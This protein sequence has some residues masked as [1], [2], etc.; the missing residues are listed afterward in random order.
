MGLSDGLFHNAWSFDLK[1]ACQSGRLLEKGDP[2][3]A[4]EAMISH[5][6]ST[7]TKRFSHPKGDD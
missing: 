3:V 5:I 1:M 4:K 6:K 2:Q 7:Y